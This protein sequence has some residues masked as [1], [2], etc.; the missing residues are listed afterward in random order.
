MSVELVV[1]VVVGFAAVV[2]LA[3]GV[4]AELWWRRCHPER[5]VPVL[6]GSGAAFLRDVVG[7]L[8]TFRTPVLAWGLLALVVLGAL[9]PSA[10]QVRDAG[11]L[12]A[13][14]FGVWSLAPFV[15]MSVVVI[16]AARLS[17]ATLV[18]VAPGVLA[19]GGLGVWI[20]EDFDIAAS[21]TASLVFLWLPVYQGGVVALTTVA[22]AGAYLLVWLARRS[23]ARRIAAAGGV[24]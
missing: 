21:S 3:G 4:V 7:P 22:A 23:R 5:V 8:L 17:R 24:R 13:V 9:Y 11:V 18:V 12:A 20:L 19:L 2:A 10:V 6:P 14:V 1:T 16:A 15:V